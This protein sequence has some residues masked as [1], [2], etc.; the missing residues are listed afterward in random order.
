MGG[1]AEEGTGG[2]WSSLSTGELILRLVCAPSSTAGKCTYKT[3]IACNKMHA[4]PP[5]I[6]VFRIIIHKMQTKE[7]QNGGGLR[8]KLSLHYV[9]TK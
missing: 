6:F 3:I 8:T 9:C 5:T 4:R 1:R 7:Q 2:G